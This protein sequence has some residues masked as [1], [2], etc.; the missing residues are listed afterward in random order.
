MSDEEKLDSSLFEAISHDKRI[1]ILKLLRDNPMK[2]SEFKHAL[3][4]KSSG[5]VTH[6]LS[7][8]DDL[9]IQNEDGYYSLTEKGKQALLVI[10]VGTLKN[11]KA[12]LQTAG[13]L[14]ALIFYS[15]FVTVWIFQVNIVVPLIGIGMSAAY[16][17]IY[18]IVTR[19]R[20]EKGRYGFIFGH[21]WK[22]REQLSG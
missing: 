15:I 14:S 9:I 1:Q 19:R 18:T 7:K 10:E 11:Q 4:I 16:Y 5:N 13:M 2:F 6:H 21:G 20:L 8:L 12:I 3:G 22:K 17:L